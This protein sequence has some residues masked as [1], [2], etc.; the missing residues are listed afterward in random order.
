MA[1][2]VA[3]QL[4]KPV[5]TADGALS[6]VDRWNSW[7]VWPLS[8]GVASGHFSLGATFFAGEGSV[9]FR[10]KSRNTMSVYLSENVLSWLSSIGEH[11]PETL[12]TYCAFH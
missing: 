1:V 4:I 7:C 2:V 3:A 6:Y 11:T 8:A 12:R 5:A 10:M 9:F